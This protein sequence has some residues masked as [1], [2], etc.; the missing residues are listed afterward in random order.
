MT[1]NPAT[2]LP[3]RPS[4][5]LDGLDQSKGG[6]LAGRLLNLETAPGNVEYPLAAALPVDYND[7]FPV[8]SH[9]VEDTD[10]KQRSRA[11]HRSHTEAPNPLPGPG[12]RNKLE[13]LFC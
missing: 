1:E 6:L 5:I 8:W 10:D 13:S 12:R 11:G 2:P 3:E 4:P 7:S 9:T